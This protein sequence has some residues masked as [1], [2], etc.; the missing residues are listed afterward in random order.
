MEATQVAMTLR[1]LDRQGPRIRGDCDD[2]K[3]L[4]AWEVRQTGRRLKRG[5]PAIH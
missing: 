1:R 4:S 5:H 3:G 2:E